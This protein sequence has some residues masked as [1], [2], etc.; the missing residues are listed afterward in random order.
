MRFVAI[1]L[2][3]LFAAARVS[4]MEIASNGVAMAVIVVDRDAPPPDRHAATELAAF[5]GQVTNAQFQI[6]HDPSA[7]RSR[8]LVGPDAARLAD[9]KFSADGLGAEGIVIRTRGT[10]LI[11]AGGEP[12]GTLYSVYTFLEDNVGC[13]L[14]DANG[15]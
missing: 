9:P 12:R 2:P 6:T 8:I 11:L 10:D 7:G 15:K 1:A 13:P 4:G 14:V 3:I 5:L